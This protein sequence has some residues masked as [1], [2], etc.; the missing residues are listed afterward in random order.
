[1][2]ATRRDSLFVV[3]LACGGAV[4]ARRHGCSR[5][6]SGLR[7][8]G[9]RRQL[10]LAGRVDGLTTAPLNKA[11]LQAAGHPYPGHTELLA[12][13][14]GVQEVAMMLYLAPGGPIA[15]R[16]G[17]GVVHV[18]LHTSMRLAVDELTTGRILSKARLADTVTLRLAGA[19]NRAA[20]RELA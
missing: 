10:A 12:D 11:A 20:R 16:A 14:C 9:L 3:R 6:T 17:L 15:G 13:L 8:A 19:T 2:S 5:R 18:T 4:A 7:C 1:M